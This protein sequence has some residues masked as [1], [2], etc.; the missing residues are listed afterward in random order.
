MSL[1]LGLKGTPMSEVQVNEEVKL[2]RG[3]SALIGTVRLK[4]SRDKTVRLGHPW[5]FSKGIASF[6]GI[7]GGLVRVFC[8]QNTPIGIGYVNERSNIRLRMLGHFES[9][10]DR[11]IFRLIKKSIERRKILNIPSNAVRLVNGENDGLSGLIVDCYHRV[12]VIQIGTLGMEILKDQIVEALDLL[13]GAP[14]IYEKSTSISRKEEGLKSSNGWLKKDEE[15]GL[16]EIFEKDVR[17]L[18]DVV[19]GQKTGFFLDQRNMR[20]WLKDHV[21]H[22]SVL[23]LCAY[24]GG[25]SLHA[26]KSGASKVTSVDISRE[27][28]RQMHLNTELNGLKNHE[29]IEK[30]VFEFLTNCQERYDIVVLDPPAFIKSKK[31]L[32]KGAKAYREMNRLALE[33]VKNR[34]IFLSSSCSYFL[35][36]GFFETILLEASLLAKRDVQVIHRHSLALDHMKSLAFREGEYLKTVVMLC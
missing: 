10:P 3:D 32:L 31:D 11:L 27:A 29:I 15:V 34:G 23:N 4:P 28:C 1:E 17:F 26:L 8:S 9:D 7:N 5:V 35:D 12:L 2:N 16:V 25:F 33:K 18:I 19:E 22:K 30:D 13:V 21:E 20:F 6:E 24:S 14:V 36:E